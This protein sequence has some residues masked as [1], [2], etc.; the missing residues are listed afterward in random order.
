MRKNNKMRIHLKFITKQYYVSYKY[1][2][3]Q[4]QNRRTILYNFHRENFCGYI[5]PFSLHCT[6]YE[7]THT[8]TVMYMK[9]L[10]TNMR[11]SRKHM[12]YNI[13]FA[14][15]IIKISYPFIWMRVGYVVLQP[16]T[17]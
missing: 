9:A 12:T 16:S 3:E 17:S 2:I 1:C 7:H 4:E 8:H 10:N 11:E 6:H 15:T 5:S 13:K 14:T